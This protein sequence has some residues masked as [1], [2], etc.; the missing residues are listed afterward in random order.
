[1]KYH[2]FPLTLVATAVI[3]S[4]CSDSTSDSDD[5]T[6]TPSTDSAFTEITLNASAGGFGADPESAENRAAYFNF[7]TGEVIELSDTE[8]QLSTDWHMALKRTNTYFNG[9]NSGPGDI[10]SA[11]LALQENYYDSEGNEDNNVFLNSSAE[12]E[13]DNGAIELI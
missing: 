6:V 3:L 9:G 8:A 5:N 12:V 2:L 11:I 13:E 1:M 7:E 4:G 10:Q